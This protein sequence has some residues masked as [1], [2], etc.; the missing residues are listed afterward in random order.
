MFQLMQWKQNKLNY[1][2]IYL[3]LYIERKKKEFKAALAYDQV[4]II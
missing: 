3:F 4:Q 1:N 2:I